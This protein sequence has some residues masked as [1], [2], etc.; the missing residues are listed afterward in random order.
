MGRRSNTLPSTTL[1]ALTWRVLQVNVLRVLIARIHAVCVCLAP[2]HV[3]S[4]SDRCWT[5]IVMG[6]NVYWAG[7]P[8]GGRHSLLTGCNCKFRDMGM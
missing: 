2:V 6:F 1:R 4:Q 5:A 7:L 3:H 8:F